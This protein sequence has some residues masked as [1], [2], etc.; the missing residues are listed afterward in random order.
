[1]SAGRCPIPGYTGHC[2]GLKFDVGHSYAWLVQH[3]PQVSRTHVGHVTVTPRGADLQSAPVDVVDRAREVTSVTRAPPKPMSPRGGIAGYTGFVP[4]SRYV[5]GTNYRKAC[6]DCFSDME[7]RTAE[8]REREEH[9]RRSR[10]LGRA[11]ASR[12]AV[13]ETG[14]AAPAAPAPALSNGAVSSAL[15]AKFSR[16]SAHS[17]DEEPL[18]IPGYSGFVPRARTSQMGVGKRFSRFADEGFHALHE[19]VERYRQS[20]ARPVSVRHQQPNGPVKS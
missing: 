12:R 2:P 3:R 7:R 13:R 16:Y 18:P 14:A 15:D 5:V 10:S 11:S 19:Q 1:M 9:A 20:H 8:R 6:D 17:K 4:G